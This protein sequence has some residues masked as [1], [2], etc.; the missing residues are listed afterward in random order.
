MQIARLQARVIQRLA[1][2][3]HGAL[4][5]V[6]RQLV[7]FGARQRHIQVL[8]AGGV[9]RDE[10][11]VDGRA[12]HAGKLDLR[13]FGRLFQALGRHFVAAQVYAVLFFEFIG[14]PVDDALVKIVAAQVRVA[15]SGQHFRHAVAHL[16]DGNVERAAAQVVHHDFLVVF[17]IHAIGKGRGRGLV[18][19]ALYIQAR[20]GAGVLA[21][22]GNR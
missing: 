12:G 11:Q 8:R 7:E 10:R 2:R 19:D 21:G 17:L 13:L 14:H 5:Q 16:D 18:D 4:Y 20:N 3:A 1:H 9:R 22:A 6:C 15:R